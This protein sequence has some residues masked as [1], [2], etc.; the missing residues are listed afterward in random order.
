[1][2]GDE[3]IT[4]YLRYVV[5]PDKLTD[6]EHYARLWVR[7]VEKFGGTHHGYF[8][9]GESPSAAFSFPGVGEEGPSNVAIALFSFPGLDEYETYRQKAAHDAECRAAT[10]YYEQTKCF[11]KY[12]RSFMRPLTR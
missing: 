2:K 6:F 10:A 4:C 3:L 7:L 5:S 1:V 8:L 12:E 9:P 11:I